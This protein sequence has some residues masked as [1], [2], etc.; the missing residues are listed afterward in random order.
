MCLNQEEHMFVGGWVT[1]KCSNVILRSRDVFVRNRHNTSI[2]QLKFRD[3]REISGK[4][5]ITLSSGY[6]VIILFSD[7][8]L[9]SQDFY[10]SVCILRSKIKD[11]NLEARSR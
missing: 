8:S 5:F 4:G 3:P 9:K 11:Y 7:F 10:W 2:D 6:K 1:K